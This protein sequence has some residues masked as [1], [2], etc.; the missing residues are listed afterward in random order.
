LE[1]DHISQIKKIWD[2][3]AEEYSFDVQSIY[4]EAVKLQLLLE[5]VKSDDQC[6]DVGSA[7][8]L[9]S[10]AISSCVNKVYALDLSYKMV[11]LLKEKATEKKIDN[12]IPVQ[13]NG[14]NLSFRSASVDVVFCYATL[15]LIPD[16]MKFFREVERVLVPGG[17]AILDVSNTRN[18]AQKYWSRFY[19]K[20][21]YIAQRTFTYKDIQ[22]IFQELGFSIEK[23]APV[24]LLDQ[25]KY[26]P[27]IHRLKFLDRLVH[28]YKGLELDRDARWSARFPE[29]ANHWYFVIKKNL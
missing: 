20:S 6:L 28:S 4:K 10:L 26:I 29:S 21:G 18:L 5:T 14:E 27:G 25:W 2:E 15:S 16:P 23:M 19:V 3:R 8:G 7:S 1:D 12:L 13:Q 24:G 11:D 9:F 17:R 22:S